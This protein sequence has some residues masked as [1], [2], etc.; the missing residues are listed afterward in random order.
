MCANKFV[1]S[2]THECRIP[3]AA[4]LVFVLQG[5]PWGIW[6]PFLLRW[7]RLHR[8]S[9]WV[10]LGPLWNLRDGIWKR[11]DMLPSEHIGKV[12]VEMVYYSSITLSLYLYI[13]IYIRLFWFSM[14]FFTT[15]LWSGVPYES[16]WRIFFKMMTDD[17]MGIHFKPKSNWH[18]IMRT[19]DT[20]FVRELPPTEALYMCKTPF[21][22]RAYYC[23]WFSSRQIL[24]R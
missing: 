6:I 1:T 21:V 7:A 19:M 4:S 23:C 10:C 5:G 12:L 13:Y 11:M 20:A 2:I 15:V 3:L 17:V 16:T 22:S 8:T 18:K 14:I 9:P 24:N